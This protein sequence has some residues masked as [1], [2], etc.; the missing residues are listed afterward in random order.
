MENGTQMTLEQYQ[1]E[2][3][4]KPIVGVSDFL[5]RISALQESKSDFTETVLACFSELCTLLDSKK[6]KRNPLTCS[7]RT[8]KI[9]LAL[10]ED[11]TLPDFSLKWTGGGTMQNGKFSTRK[12][13]EF[14]KTGNAVSLS[15]ILEAEVDEQY[16][17]SPKATQRL[18]SY[19]D[20]K[21][22]Y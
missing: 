10:M 8:L 22:V 21:I 20:S 18:L 9:F 13:S 7:L 12:T 2:T 15:D 19:R 5:A 17:L 16:F 6:K 3:F 1:P 14:R 11:G 4:L